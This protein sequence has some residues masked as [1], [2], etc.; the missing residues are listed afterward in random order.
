MSGQTVA[1]GAQPTNRTIF[2]ADNL[3]VLRGIDS[4]TIDLI[5]LDPPFNTGKQWHAPIGSD[6]EGASFNDIWAWD[7]LA[8]AEGETLATSVKRQWLN[9]LHIESPIRAVVETAEATAGE[10]MGAYLAFMAMRLVEMHRVL[11]PTGSIYLHCDQTAGHY[12]KLLMDAIFGRRLFRNEIV[13]AYTGPGNVKRW[14]PRKHDTILFFA[15]SQSTQFNRNAVRVPYR[16]GLHNDGTVFSSVEGDPDEVREQEGRGKVVQDWWTDIG[17]GA[18]ISKNERVGYPTQKPLALLERIIKASSNRGDIVLDPFCGCATACVA[19]ENLRRQW[20]GIDTSKQAVELVLKRLGAGESSAIR[21]TDIIARIDAPE[22]TDAPALV[23]EMP[24]DPS[25]AKEAVKQRLYEQQDGIC[26][27]CHR[28][29]PEEFADLMD[30]D[31]IKPK[32]RGGLH[33]WPNVQLLCRTCNVRK[34]SGTM[35]QLKKKLGQDVA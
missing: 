30:L 17:A 5:Y 13:W 18:H 34:G 26:N 33:T 9:A 27:G 10:E 2:T 8:E 11:K 25:L 24:I 23:D 14:F 31:H 15:K 19:A 12:L 32:S 22:R 28:H 21:R 16:D 4:E 6:A 20:I 35:A 1:A 29:F 7:D 3:P